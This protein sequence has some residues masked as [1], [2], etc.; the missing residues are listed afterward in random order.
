MLVVE[1]PDPDLPLDKIEVNTVAVLMLDDGECM[2]A[3]I[4]KFNDELD[5]L[6]VDVLSSNRPYRNSGQQG[7]T[8]PISRIVSCESQPRAEE[9]WPYSDPCRGASFSLAR[10]V[11]LATLF[12]CLIPGSLFPFILLMKRPHG[13]QEASA[14]VYTIAA[15]FSTFAAAR[16]LRPYMFTCPAVQTQLP[17]VLLRHLGFL[18]A[19]LALQTAALVARPNLPDW[20]NT[21]SAGSSSTVYGRGVGKHAPFDIALMLLC[22]GL[23]YAEVF[24]NRSLL[25]RAHRE[26]SA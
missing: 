15:V 7:R 18:V 26:F 12:L 11:L 13:L 21:E 14:I 2:T 25:D 16:G 5:G 8:I 20:W 17:R 3:D 10:F 9:P 22:L 1:M 6:I 4:L 24:T 23:G 19:L